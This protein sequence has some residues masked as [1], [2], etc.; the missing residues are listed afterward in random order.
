[1]TTIQIP[2]HQNPSESQLDQQSLAHTPQPP[3]SIDIP[4]NQSLDN[5]T[6]SHKSPVSDYPTSRLSSARAVSRTTSLTRKCRIPCC[7]G[8]PPAGREQLT[9]Y[10][11]PRS[12]HAS[13]S[14]AVCTRR[15]SELERTKEV[16][17]KVKK[18]REKSQLFHSQDS[19]LAKSKSGSQDKLEC[20]RLGELKKVQL[21]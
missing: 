20:F 3:F 13:A 16:W 5:E 6:S 10:R 12:H 4:L 15:D 11:G 18:K 2:W 19:T 9:S 21:I 14:G 1:M 17:R 8:S 7:S